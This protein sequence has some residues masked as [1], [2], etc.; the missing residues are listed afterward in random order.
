MAR[1]EIPAGYRTALV[2]TMPRSG[3]WLS[4]YFL[5][6]FDLF[7]TGRQEFH[8]RLDL[9]ILHGLRLGK[10]HTHCICPGFLEH[11]DGPH[12]Q[13]WD[14]LAFY[15]PGFNFGYGRFIENNE[16]AFDP[17]G[18]P[19][20]RIVYL[21]RNPLDQMVSFYRHLEHHRQET[22]RTYVD[23]TGEERPFESLGHYIEAAG[24]GAYIKQYFT[25]HAVAE[26]SGN[27]LMVPYERLTREGD[28]PFE[29]MLAF[30]GTP[31]DSAR[32]L[33]A[34]RKARNASR[35]ESLRV[36][37]RA[38]PGSLARDQAGEGETHM[39]GGAVGKW[40][41]ALADADIARVRHGL[42]EF[43]LSLDAFQTE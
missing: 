25:Y 36:L 42:A 26:R 11:Y 37:E 40:K 31:L 13:I 32:R 22:A 33:E 3:T 2:A 34:F 12:R 41:D 16:T 30:L 8:T 5:E 35:A 9:H 29:E 10:L 23:E 17:L 1:Y 24:L 15:T 27:V 19:G 28:R 38:M 7:L 39:R 14:R 18:Q 20:A 4:F 21:Y 6:F 43:G